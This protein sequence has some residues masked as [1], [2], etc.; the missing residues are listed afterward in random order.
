[1][2]AEGVLIFRAMLPTDLIYRLLI[3]W[4]GKLYIYK[5]YNLLIYLIFIIN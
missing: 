3:R 1:M 4:I 2:D 5:M